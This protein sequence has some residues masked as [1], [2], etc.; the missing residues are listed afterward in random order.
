VTDGRTQLVGRGYDV[1]ADRFIEWR[2]RTEGDQRARWRDELADRLDEGAR[3][4]ELGCGA[5][6]PDTKALAARFR[7]TGVDISAEQIRRARTNVPA[8]EF[9]LGDIT[10]LDIE[11]ASYDA[12]ASFYA[13]NHIPRELLAGLL[14]DIDSWLKPAGLLLTAFATSD[15]ES[16]T[17]EWLGT[18]MFFSSFTP[19]TNRRLLV[20]AGFEILR[21]EIVTMLEPSPDGGQGQ[22]QWVLARR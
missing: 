5:G 16:W 4:L 15:T 9:L 13:F 19:D 3:I 14:A 8:A 11:P 6:V 18:T 20:E 21:D 2:D 22:W 7:V 1:M 10:A 17:G 12:V